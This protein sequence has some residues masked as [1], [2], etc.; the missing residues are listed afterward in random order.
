MMIERGWN[1]G[2][3]VVIPNYCVTLDC[4]H[5]DIPIRI[6]VDRKY[7]FNCPYKLVMSGVLKKKL[8]TI[9][10]R[11]KVRYLLHNDELIVIEPKESLL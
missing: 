8:N 3:L 1:T 2:E 11:H 6:K 5:G 7:V 9:D 4:P 10:G